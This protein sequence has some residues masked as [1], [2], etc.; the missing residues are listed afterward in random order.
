MYTVNQNNPDNHMLELVKSLKN[1]GFWHSSGAKN[2]DA[3]PF[4]DHNL[5]ADFCSTWDNLLLDEYMRDGGTYRYR[6]YSQ[7]KFSCKKNTL[8]LLP[9]V[10]YE[11]PFEV[12]KL[13]GGFPRYFSPIEDIFINNDF[14]RNLI[15]WLGRSYSEVS[16]HLEW[17]IKLHPYRIVAMNGAGEPS[18]EGLHRDGVDFIC[19]FLTKKINVIGGETIITDLNNEELCRFTLEN[20]GDIMIGNDHLTK[21]GVSAIESIN[22]KKPFAFRDV[23][24]IAFTKI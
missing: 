7:I 2:F 5:W 12:N 15:K 13:N 18:P 3:W 9:H 4:F 19:S 20:P 22:N 17:N 21:H 23:L 14:F 24:V 1:D 16:G 11:Q 8:D 6:R 10:P